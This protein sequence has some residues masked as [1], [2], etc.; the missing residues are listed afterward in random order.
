MQKGQDNGS[1]SKLVTSKITDFVGEDKS[2]VS[3]G[4]YR[5]KLKLFLIV[6]ALAVTLDQLSKL[7]IRAHLELGESLPITDR[8]SLTYIGN[9][10]SALGLLANQT[11]LLI[12]ISIA[13]VLFILLFL[14]YLSP[15]TTLSM[16]SIGLVL[17]G[18]LGNL[19]DRLSFGYVTDFIDIRL[20][21]NFH[22]PTF[23]IADTA[24]T[25]GILTL[26]YSFYKSGVFRKT[27]ERNH[28]P[29]N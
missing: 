3:P 16:L 21:S 27:Y 18:A 7:G 1:P 13:S 10:G 24:I 8:L 14:R 6:I 2:K 28:R 9:T 12:T 17:G 15:V 22:W 26:I 29:Q 11:F 23:N 5:G 20:W 19:I 25:V 4:K